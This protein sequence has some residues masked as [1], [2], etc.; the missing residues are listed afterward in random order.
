MYSLGIILF[1]MCY[2]LRTAME[3]AQ[4]LGDL[5]KE[6]YSLPIMFDEPEK[7]LQREII[8]SLVRHKVSE[9]P[10]SQ[11]LLR[12]GKIPIQDEDETMRTALQLLSNKSS[13]F[14]ARLLKEMFNQSQEE[15]NAKD[16]TYDLN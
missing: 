1:E 12:S 10:S 6:D 2:P 11:E 8:K 3:R 14:Y 9:R 5:R 15:S 7:L 13:P 4:T 16:Y